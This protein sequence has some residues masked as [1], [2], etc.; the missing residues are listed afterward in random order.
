MTI[1]GLT[2]PQWLTYLEYTG[3]IIAHYNQPI[4]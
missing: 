3:I 4:A 2:L 1:F